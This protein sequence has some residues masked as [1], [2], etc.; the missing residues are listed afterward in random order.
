L[1]T[2]QLRCFSQNFSHIHLQ[3]IRSVDDGPLQVFRDGK[4]DGYG[5][6]KGAAPPMPPARDAAHSRTIRQSL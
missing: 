1:F 3:A 4:R 6:V 5:R 2:P